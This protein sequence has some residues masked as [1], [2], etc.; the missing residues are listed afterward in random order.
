MPYVQPLD[1]SS[2]PEKSQSLLQA[3]EQKMGSSLNIFNT[4]AHQPDV[5]SGITQLDEGIHQDLPGKLRELAYVMASHVNRC[6]YC[7]HYHTQLAKQAGVSQE[8]LD[9]LS[10]YQQSDLFD[11]Q[12]RAVLAYSEQLTKTAEVEAGVVEKLK[13]F[14]DDKQLVSLAATVGLANFTNRFNHGL[15][16]QL[17]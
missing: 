17:P 7:S 10:A 16:I 4:M 14:L 5:L 3:I 11:E 15:D 9:A 13:A 12:E 6:G 1:Q 8:Q 2:A